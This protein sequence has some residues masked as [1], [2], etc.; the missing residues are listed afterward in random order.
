MDRAR[1]FRK[2]AAEANRGRQLQGWRYGA[3]LKSLAVA[4][5]RVRRQSGGSFAE[6]AE[7]LG[8]STLTLSRWLKAPGSAAAV[9][10]AVEVVAEP[11]SSVEIEAGPL[12]A[13]TPGGLRIEG[14]MWSQVLELA[15]VLG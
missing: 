5:C 3:E 12:C 11:E 6:I 7:E 15:R 13:I 9:F 1:R 8:V 14:L 10:R 4:H 2:A